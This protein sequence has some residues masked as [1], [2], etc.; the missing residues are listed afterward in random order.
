MG[1]K[2]FFGKKN[3]KNK[4]KRLREENV[5][6]FMVV[7]QTAYIHSPQALNKVRVLLAPKVEP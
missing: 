6:S 3:V 1:V 5:N 4:G 7:Q 2:P